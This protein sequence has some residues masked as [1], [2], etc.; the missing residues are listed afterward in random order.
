MVYIHIRVWEESEIT[1]DI[2]G[3]HLNNL[4]IL[5]NFYGEREGGSQQYGS[6]RYVM[7]FITTK[8]P[9]VVCSQTGASLIGHAAYTFVAQWT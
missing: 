2:L 8:M 1:W 6:F 3:Y 7:K 4:S 9:F 5:F